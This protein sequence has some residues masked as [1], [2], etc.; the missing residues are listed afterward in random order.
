MLQV[1]SFHP[2][3]RFAGTAAADLGNYT[4]RAPYPTLHLLRE[5]S[6]E[7]AV[8]AVKAG[9]VVLVLSDRNIARGK[10]PIHALLAVGALQHRLIQEGLRCDC[11]LIVETAVARD[12]HQFACL[13]GY[14]ASCV[15]PYLAYASLYE[16]ARNGEIKGKAPEE[17]GTSYR[18]G[19]NKGL[20]KIMS[21][22]GISTIASYRGAQLFEI[23]GLHDE[24]VNLCFQGTVSRIQGARFA[25]LEAEQTQLA[26]LAWT[27]RK[28]RWSTRSVGS[29]PVALTQ[30]TA[31]CSWRWRR[32]T[33][34]SIA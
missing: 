4:N 15:Y 33:S 24:I 34:P 10:L 5:R 6:V 23:V 18:K 27:P 26:L 29:S 9:T 25:E 30:R 3:F 20:Y 12:P 32:F 16:M 21:K 1:A 7:R 11:N 17:L 13:I 19:I 28:P 14:G 8:A 31:R 2:H 22:M